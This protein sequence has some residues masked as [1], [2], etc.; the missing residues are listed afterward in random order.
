MFKLL[1]TCCWMVAIILLPVIVHAQQ[2]EAASGIVRAAGT[3]AP[4]ASA[5]VAALKNGEII[6]SVLTDKDGKFIFYQLPEGAVSFS[7]SHKSFETQSLSNYTIKSEETLSVL[8]DMKPLGSAPKE[9]LPRPGSAKITVTGTV[10]DSIGNPLFSVNITSGTKTSI[11]TTT[12]ANGRFILD[13][14]PNDVLQISYSGYETFE[15]RVPEKPQSRLIIKLHTK[16]TAAADEV[17]VTAYGKKQL[18]EAVV[19]S[20]STIKPENL[21]I[22][23]SNLTNALAG[24]VAGIIGFQTGGQPGLDNSQFFIRGVT[25][26]GYRQDP[27]I[28]IDNVELTTNDLA[29]LQVNDIASFSILKDASATALYGARGANGVILVTTKTGKTGK[30]TINLVVEN[31]LSQPTKSLQLT[32]P[33]TY[34]KMYNEA[35][36][37]R[38]PLATPLFNADQIYNATQTLK[39]APGSNKYVYPAVDWLDLL[40]KKRSFTERANL[41]VNGGSDFAHYYISASYSNDNG[42]LKSDPANNFKNNLKFNNYQLRSNIDFKIFPR[43]VVSV[44]LWGNFNEYNGPITNNASFSTD[45]FNMATHTSPASFP[46]YYAPD[47][48]NAKAQHILFGNAIGGSGVN[49]IG[50]VNPYAQM[51]RGYQRYSESRMSAT[52]KLDQKLDFV[53]PGLAFYGFFTT[54]RYSYFDNTM[55]YNPFYYMIPPGGYDIG[56]NKYNLLWI[57]SLPNGNPFDPGLGAAGN[58]NAATEYLVYAPGKKDATS[59][60][61]LQGQ[62]DYNRQFGDHG[63]GASLILVRQQTLKANGVDPNTSQPSLAYSL[64]YRNLNLAGR[65]SY[66]YKTRYFLEFNFGYD[67]SERFD[68]SHRYGF[69]PTIGGSWMVSKEKFW[70]GGIADII[71]SLKLRGS[72]GKTGNDQIGNQ[73]FFYLSNVNLQANNGSSFGLNNGYSRPGVVINNYQNSNITWETGIISNEAIEMTLFRKLDLI[74]E[75]WQQHRSNI[76]MG[77]NIPSSMGLEAGIYSNVGTADI[78]GLD[79]TANYTQ[80]FS[81]KLS[82]AFMSNLTFSQGRYGNYEEPPYTNEPW[83][84]KSGS[85]LNQ[86]FGYIAER[87][88]VDNKEAASSPSQNFGG[89]LP[90]GGDIKY[91]DVNGDGQITVADQVPIGLPTVPEIVYGFGLSARYK[92]FDL[93]FR[94]QGQARVSFFIKPQD[95]SPFVI[96]PS[97]EHIPGQS[98]VLT[99]VANDYWSESK[100]NLYAFYPRLGTSSTLITNNLQTSTW[101]MRNGDF[102]RLKMVELGYNLSQRIAERI[103]FKSCRIYINA[104]NPLLFSKF[105]LWDAEL[106][107]NAFTYPIQKVYNLGIN[108][109]L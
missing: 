94:F 47:S 43:T 31:S 64:P 77:R 17:V 100:Q 98:Q 106:G 10:V 102:L 53:T 23:A 73:R 49:S 104:F 58:S 95:I 32:D 71:T 78:K 66:N 84:R 86:Q 38:N 9:K 27:L 5:S 13:A 82:V 30:P 61:Q 2:R 7:V 83:R 109:S 57:N 45:L 54:N 18:K 50:Y 59:F 29:R 41:S 74:A 11:G 92:G 76:L 97:D 4:I 48:A 55:A 25:T 22:P 21:L 8:I 19:G 75:Y 28:L 81:N 65:V 80:R 99:A 35:L 70:Q 24:Q 46:A 56:S 68:P 72:Y 87:L 37:T 26:F 33:I 15:Y 62:L 79:L 105:K 101:W 103:K 39:N 90:M 1:R 88:F 108:V 3:R 52:L 85:L 44:M 42:M 34:M 63:I 14:S 40:F 96:P 20:V 16:I 51:L 93:G 91:R 89:P 6:S 67:G 107:G 36:T 12:D 60:L 69:F